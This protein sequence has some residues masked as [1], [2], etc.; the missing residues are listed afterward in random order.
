M[1]VIQLVKK[2]PALMESCSETPAIA[3]HPASGRS[4]QLQYDLFNDD[5]NTASP[6]LPTVNS[7]KMESTWKEK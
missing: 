7:M 4:T 2:L 3:P 5:A 6:C 1:R